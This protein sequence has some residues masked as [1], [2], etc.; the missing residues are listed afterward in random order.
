MARY[1]VLARELAKRRSV[2][3]L[4]RVHTNL[5]DW[6]THDRPLVA[7]K[8]RDFRLEPFYPLILEDNHPNIMCVQGRQTYKTTTS[9]D[10][11]GFYSTAFPF[12]E[13]GYI[14]DNE[15]RRL[16][17]SKQRLR[18]ETFL[19]NWKLRQYV[20]FER[21]NVGVISLLNG[22]NIYIVNDEGA[23]KNIE[24]RSLKLLV[25]DEWQYH[26]QINQIQKAMYTLSRTRGRFWGFGIGGEAG[27]EYHK[28]WLRTDQREWKYKYSGSYQGWPGQEWR[29]FLKFNETGEIINENL[30][31]VLDGRW[32]ATKPENTEFRGYHVP[33]TIFA[34]IPLT[35][36]DAVEKYH[37]SPTFSIEWQKLHTS[38]SIYLSHVLGEFYKAERRPITPEMVYACMTPYRHL[39]LLS[40]EEVRA[41]KQ[42]HG[43]EIRILMGMDYGSS[44]TEPTNVVAI[45]IKFRKYG[46][47]RLAHIEKLP[48][49]KE[50][51]QAAY[52]TNLA[53]AYQVDAAVGDLGYGETIVPLMQDGGYDTQG[54][55]IIGLGRRKMMGCRTIGDETK[56][57]MEYKTQQDEHGKQLARIQIDKTTTI[58]K[59]ID[60]LGWYVDH[61]E[62]ID[63]STKRPK[64]IIPY[65]EDW[66]VDFLV[67]DF[68]AL[69]RKDLEK[70]I[71]ADQVDPRQRA[72][73]EFNH[74]PD[75]MMACIYC[76]VA[77]ENYDEDAYRIMGVR[78]R[79]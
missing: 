60:F 12:S 22:S 74:P 11:I 15:A 25:C 71:D 53:H 27:S 76:L 2:S 32:V 4:P 5:M 44:I 42:A 51:D 58:Q 66:A 3:D 64:F 43:N 37:V 24:G 68:T 39:S 65:K 9:T 16:A 13:V 73:K 40:A 26:D 55:K 1:H 54:N 49:R 59:F 31:D 47:Y 78:N 33:Q 41:L 67:D 50:P 23:Y 72:R 38:P 70:E 46:T 69:T 52:L 34:A 8:K 77:D 57:Q 75:S 30:S 29:S 79:R 48:Q 61:P 35:I 17:F 62:V 21:A 28:L 6:I 10:L 56:P 20:P 18:N 7:G 45:M 63:G 19:Q 36:K 14:V